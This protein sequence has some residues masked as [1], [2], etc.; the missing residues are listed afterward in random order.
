MNKKILFTILM[1]LFI[2]CAIAG[3]QIFA[4]PQKKIF[5]AEVSFEEAGNIVS[6][7]HLPIERV[8]VNMRT[9]VATGTVVLA[10]EDVQLHSAPGEALKIEY[11]TDSELS[12]VFSSVTFQKTSGDTYT[13]VT[14]PIIVDNSTDFIYYRIIAKTQDGSIGKFPEDETFISANLT[15]MKLKKIGPEGGTAVLQSGDQTR[16][17]TYERF[18]PDS[19]LTTNNFRIKE[20]YTTDSIPLVGSLQPIIVYEFTPADISVNNPSL[21]PTI[22]LYYGDLPPNNNNIEVKWLNGSGWQNVSFTNDTDKR[23]VTVNLSLTSTK[24]GYY[25]VFNKTALTDNDYRPEFRLLK[26]GEKMQ[27][28]NL[29]SGDVVTIFNLNG[30]Q[31]RRI[32][33]APFEWDGRRDSGGYAESGSYIYQIKV[34]GKIISGSIAFVR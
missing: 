12:P 25:G 33:A 31:I 27:F 21:M 29:Q 32:T 15:Q 18:M 23:T 24:L 11:Y 4:Y 3:A 20:L 16:G 19:L 10:G 17:D 22:S 26:F 8:S 14:D 1:F 5:R 34:S 6:I 9:L 13:F 28:R 7:L 2:S 30:Q